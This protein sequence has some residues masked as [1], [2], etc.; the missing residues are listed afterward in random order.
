MLRIFP[1]ADSFF[2]NNF[3]SDSFVSCYGAVKFLH[4]IEYISW[5]NRLFDQM[6]NEG[7]D[8]RRIKT[9]GEI[10]SKIVTV[11]LF[12]HRVET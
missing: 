3:A 6:N 9:L 2:L 12:K 7:I 8:V 1:L 10:F 5:S 11:L 4:R